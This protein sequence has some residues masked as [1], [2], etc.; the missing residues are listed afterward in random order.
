VVILLT[1]IF[2]FK[3]LN[4]AEP[5]Q[6]SLTSIKMIL[7]SSL[8]TTKHKSFENR[9]AIKILGWTVL[10]RTPYR[11]ELDPSLEFS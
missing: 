10:S 7:K 4:F 2:I 6:E 9:E 1:Q 8:N 3:T 11:A 5:F